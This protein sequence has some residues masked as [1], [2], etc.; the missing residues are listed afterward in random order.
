MEGSEM[1]V[2]NEQLMKLDDPTQHGVVE[3]AGSEAM[4]R[5]FS[6]GGKGGP[7]KL[8]FEHDDRSFKVVLLLTWR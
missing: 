6:R 4:T 3:L 8:L 2:A 5:S 1:D 7:I